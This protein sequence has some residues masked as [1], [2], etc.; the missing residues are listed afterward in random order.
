MSQIAPAPRS[1][2]HL[3]SE[4]DAMTC[5]DGRDP[6]LIVAEARPDAP[7]HRWREPTRSTATRK[8]SD[9][10]HHSGR[11]A[12]V[13]IEDHREM[14]CESGLEAKAAFVLMARPNCL[15]LQEQPDRVDYIDREGKKRTHT[16]D[17]LM[18]L[19]SGARIA[20]AVKPSRIVVKY[21]LKSLFTHIARQ[22]DP[23][24]ASAVLLLTDGM[25]PRY[26]VQNG[27]LIH[28]ARRHPDHDTD[29]RVR[30]AVAALHGTTTIDDILR[31]AGLDGHDH[32]FY[33]V[34]RAIGEG[35]LKPTER[36]LI[37]RSTPI[38]RAIPGGIGVS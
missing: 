36:G 22:M 24:F 37:D 29:R 9:V 31:A 13:T 38:R 5:V 8:P 30:E 11:P 10:S 32:G 28:D 1:E 2:G 35:L 12:I 17:F 4:A 7:A 19:R 15:R 14:L 16:F 33:A 6:S 18:T 27:R 34:V 21:D 23:A 26:E 20:V 25:M 3:P